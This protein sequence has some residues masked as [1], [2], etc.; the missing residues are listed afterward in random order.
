MLC[1]DCLFDWLVTLDCYGYFALLFGVIELLFVGAIAA[2]VDMIGFVG[3]FEFGFVLFVCGYC[4]LLS[5]VCVDA[6]LF[7]VISVV[8]C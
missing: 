1:V 5:F 7:S 6:V 2:A 4:G 3:W 8:V